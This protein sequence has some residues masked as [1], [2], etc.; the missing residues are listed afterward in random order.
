VENRQDK[1]I[2]WRV[3]K[4]D[5]WIIR[6]YIYP[7]GGAFVEYTA[8]FS[9]G[10]WP[11]IHMT[12]G[13]HPETGRRKWARG[14]ISMGRFAVGVFPVGQVAVGIFPVGQAAFGLVFA[15]GQAAFAY[16]AIGQLAVAWYLAIGQLAVAQ[17]AI[18]QLAVGNYCIGQAALGAHIY[19]AKI[20]NAAVL[21]HFREL[22]PILK[23]LTAG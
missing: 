16:A 23:Q 21:E 3:T 8:R 15:L 17:N 19:T 11:L 13:R 4:T 2:D 5:F 22:L 18:G 9:F 10:S 7:A 12:F 1:P 20:K 14:I 6:S